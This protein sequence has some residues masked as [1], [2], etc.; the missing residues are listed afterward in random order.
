MALEG[1]RPRFEFLEGWRRQQPPPSRH[2]WGS[3]INWGVTA[4][5]GAPQEHASYWALYMPCNDTGT[6]TVPILQMRT[7]RQRGKATHPWATHAGN[8]ATQPEPWLPFWSHAHPHSAFQMWPV[9]RGPC[10]GEDTVTVTVTIPRWPPLLWGC[11]S[12]TQGCF[13]LPYLWEHPDG[14][15]IHGAANKYRSAADAGV[16]RLKDPDW[17]GWRG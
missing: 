11:D 12:W 8:K 9:W 4:L 2:A 6:L 16:N 15:H 10:H 1:S 7:L 3:E 5:R 17:T 14:C 13:I